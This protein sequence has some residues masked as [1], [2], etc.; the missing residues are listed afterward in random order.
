MSDIVPFGK[1]KG[2]PVEDMLADEG[3]MAWLE[4]QPW[5]RERFSHLLKKRDADAMSRTPVHNRLQALFLDAAYQAAFLRVALPSEKV[6]NAVVSFEDSVEVDFSRRR[7]HGDVVMR[8]EVERYDERDKEI[9]TSRRNLAV[10]IKPSV[11]D[12]YPGV[13]RQM[14]RNLS[15]VLFVDS[16]IGEGATEAQFVAIFAASGKHVVFKRDVD[17]EIARHEARA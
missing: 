4:A 10:E 15:H 13:L 2:Q 7:A 5:F 6:R 14:A 1:Y 3:Y 8:L 12:E 17:N 16:Y 11:A 9:Y